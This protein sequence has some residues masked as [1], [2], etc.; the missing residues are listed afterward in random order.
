MRGLEELEIVQYIEEN[1]VEGG[2]GGESRGLT[3]VKRVRH[4]G[5]TGQEACPL[6]FLH[7]PQAAAARVSP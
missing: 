2:I 3:L 1:P 4:I 6:E 5:M 7:I